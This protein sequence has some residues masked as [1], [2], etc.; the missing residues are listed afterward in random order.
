MGR[1]E[2]TRAQ[3]EAYRQG[4]RSLAPGDAGRLPATGVTW[5]QAV[6]FCKHLTNADPTGATYR[7]AREAEWEFAAR[8]AEGRAYP[9]GATPAT[10]RRANHLGTDDGFEG[11]A[12]VGSFAGGSTPQGVMDLAGNVS[13]W[14]ADWYGAYSAESAQDPVGP[15]TGTSR[16]VR[17]SSYKDEV[18]WARSSA[19]SYRREDG[20]LPF[21]GFRV[22]RE[23]TDEERAFEGMEIGE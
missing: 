11:L 12:P 4:L 15:V 14:C 16:A 5:Q 17:G 8:G 13:E 1:H 23:L 2:V 7:L 10:Q 18:Q 20:P 22:V 3:Y 9:W 19:R 21:I 6:D